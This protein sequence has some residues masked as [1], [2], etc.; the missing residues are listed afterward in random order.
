MHQT[1]PGAPARPSE[2][3]PNV[4]TGVRRGDESRIVGATG[5][6]QFETLETPFGRECFPLLLLVEC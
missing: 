4:D 6:G 3:M 2:W 5:Q 1:P